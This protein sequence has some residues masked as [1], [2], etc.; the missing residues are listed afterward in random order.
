MSPTT[1][2][3]TITAHGLIFDLDGT[4]ISTLEVT[5]KIYTQY[6]HKFN[7]DPAPVLA[8]CHG[9]PTLQ[10]LRM[11]YP[12]ST[13]TIEFANQMEHDSVIHLDGLQVIPGAD[14]LLRSLPDDKWSIFT[15]GMPMLAHPRIKHLKLPM[16]SVFITPEN[17]THGKPH[18]EGYVLAAKRMGM[19]PRHCV[20]FEDAVA[21]VK[22]GRDSGA[23]VVGIRTLLSDKQLK[24]VGAAYTVRDMTRVAV[25]VNPDG[26]LALTI[27]ES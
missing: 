15:S 22:A 7:I 1:L 16:P 9:I 6:C 14:H 12:P 13:H 10:V 18:P 27:D 17:I 3:T 21:G 19:D 24:D 5:E 20:V 4:L 25:S 23:V 26:T 2:A 11:F 8:G